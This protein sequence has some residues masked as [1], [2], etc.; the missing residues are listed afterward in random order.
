[1]QEKNQHRNLEDFLKDYA[2]AKELARTI[3]R[4]MLNL[5]LLLKYEPEHLRAVIHCYETLYHLKKLILQQD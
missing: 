2:G 1:M 4:A 5:V 3:D